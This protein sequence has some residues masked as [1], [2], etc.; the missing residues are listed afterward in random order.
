MINTIKI[1]NEYPVQYN[2]PHILAI[3]KY[4]LNQSILK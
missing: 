2:K 3:L 4:S 1:H